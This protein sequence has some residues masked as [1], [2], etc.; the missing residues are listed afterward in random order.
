[1]K[2]IRTELKVAKPE[3]AMNIIHSQK[4]LE[5]T[6]ENLK[7]LLLIKKSRPADGLSYLSLEVDY[8]INDNLAIL[9]KRFSR[10]NYEG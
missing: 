1:M 2:N 4:P 3:E 10:R 5:I 6:P 9:K 8:W 7:R